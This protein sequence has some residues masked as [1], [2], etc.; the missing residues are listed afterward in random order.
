MVDL[1]G[2]LRLM[3]TS[4]PRLGHRR[5][6]GSL[7]PAE[8][9]RTRIRTAGWQRFAVNRLPMT[10]PTA[11]APIV[12]TP[13][14]PPPEL[15]SELT[16]ISRRVD[17]ASSQC[18][19]DARPRRRPPS[20]VTTR[21]LRGR[22]RT[23]GPLVLRHPRVRQSGSST[24]SDSLPYLADAAEIVVDRLLVPVEFALEFR[25]S[26]CHVRPGS[27]GVEVARELCA[28]VDVNATLSLGCASGFLHVP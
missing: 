9:S 1:L 7:E 6:D 26:L 20:A 28:S 15:R 11:Q 10:V 3:R 23:G 14:G 8:L 12:A 17:M 4:V 24:V 16:A 21:P 5:D 22:S 25:I 13:H 18:V 2:D 27:G 19:S